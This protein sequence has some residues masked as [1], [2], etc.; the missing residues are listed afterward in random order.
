MFPTFLAKVKAAQPGTNE[1]PKFADLIFDQTVKL[2]ENCTFS[3]SFI[4][5]PVPNVSWFHNGRPLQKTN[6]INVRDD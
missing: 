2:G 4:G 5:Q 3:A 1:P 6:D